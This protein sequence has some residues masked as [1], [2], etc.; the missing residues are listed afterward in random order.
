MV[1]KDIISTV[2]TKAKSSFL[3][4]GGGTLTG[5][6]YINGSEVLHTGSD[7][8]IACNGIGAMSL[9]YGE[10]IPENADLDNYFLNGNYCCGGSA[11]GAT[12][13]NNPCNNAFIMK[14]WGRTGHASRD[15]TQYAWQYQ[16]QLLI[17]LNNQWYYRGQSNGSSK[18]AYWSDW[19][20]IVWS[21]TSGNI[22]NVGTLSANIVSANTVTGAV[23]N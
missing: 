9:G 18:Q 10:E 19:K 4:V 21:D 8:V 22:S 17:G 1:I 6:L 16:G 5:N 7:P 20:R 13:A 2:W 14:E 11:T 3:S 15:P 23:Y 12:I